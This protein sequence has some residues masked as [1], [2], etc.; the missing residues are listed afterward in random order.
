MKSTGREYRYL[1]ERNY[2]IIYSYQAERQ[3]SY[4]ETVFDARHN[5]EKLRV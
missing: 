1:V 3:V 5:P 2:K 4:I